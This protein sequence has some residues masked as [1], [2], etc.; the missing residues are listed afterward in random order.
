MAGLAY[1]AKTKNLAPEK[2]KQGKSLVQALK[3]E[4]AIRIE[5]TT[6][7]LRMPARRF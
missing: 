7:G 4:P 5:R 6:C 3:L 1:A 2:R